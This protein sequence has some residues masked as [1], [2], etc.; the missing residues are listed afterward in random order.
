MDNNGVYQGCL[1]VS[2]ERVDE[3]SDWLLAVG[4]LS[5]VTELGLDVVADSRDWFDTVPGFGEVR[6]IGDSEWKHVGHQGREV[7]TLTDDVVV[8]AN[9]SF[10]SQT[11]APIVIVIDPRDAFG[12]GAHPTTQLCAEALTRWIRDHPDAASCVDL[13]CGTGVLSILAG[14]LGVTDCVAVDIDPVAV[15]MTQANAARNEVRV[16]TRC[17]D[18]TRR[19]IDRQFDI[20]V[21]NLLTG[22]LERAMDRWVEWVNPGGVCIMSGVSAQ[23]AGDMR[24]C[25]ATRFISVDETSRDGWHAFVA[26][27]AVASGVF[28]RA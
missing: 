14:K 1:F 7:V 15:A 16:D 5:V 22:T 13:G 17:G 25:L 4:A 26:T 28:G 21:A 18:I 11:S 2:I 24:R 3:V 9:E 19:C 12:D 23:W 6:H 27:S 8:V 10:I 20:V